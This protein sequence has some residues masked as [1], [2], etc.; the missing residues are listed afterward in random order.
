[1]IRKLLENLIIDILRGKYGTHQVS[2]Y[3]DTSKRRFHDFSVLLQNLDSHKA[4]F[5]CI[6]PDLD[7]PIIQSIN[8]YRETGNSAA[9]SID[10]NLTIEQV[11]QGKDDINHLVQYLLH[12]FQ[13]L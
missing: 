1:L 13:R 3:Y 5:H 7:T 2:L 12:I 6:A 10:A 8:Q 4:D 11:S 9:H